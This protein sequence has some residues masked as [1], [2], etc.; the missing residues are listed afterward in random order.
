[1]PVL[2]KTETNLYLFMDSRQI[3]RKLNLKNKFG[4]GISIIQKPLDGHFREKVIREN[5]WYNDISE[6]VYKF[7]TFL[8]LPIIPLGCYRVQTIDQ[9]TTVEGKEKMNILELLGIYIGYYGIAIIG[10]LSFLHFV[11]VEE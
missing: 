9:R 10:I 6:V 5:V 11:F 8:Y 2:R 1:M 3:E 4:F 7:V